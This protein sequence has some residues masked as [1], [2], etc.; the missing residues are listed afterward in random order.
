MRLLTLLACYVLLSTS[1]LLLLRRTLDVERSPGDG[2]IEKVLTPDA[3]IGALLY[4]A[5]F[6]LWLVT[7]QRYPVTTVYPVFV[8]AGF[9]GVALG[10]WLVLGEGF[11]AGRAIGAAVVLAGIVLLAR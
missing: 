8:G 3:A 5:S 10:G 9:V 11:G 2:F 6:V 4:V 1:G 7:L